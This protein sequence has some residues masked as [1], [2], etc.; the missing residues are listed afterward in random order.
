MASKATNPVAE[1]DEQ[2]ANYDANARRFERYDFRALATATIHPVR[3]TEK[4]QVCYV[5]T[6]DLSR[7]G[8]SILHPV[9][10]AKNQQIDVELS[11]GR[12]FTLAVQWTKRLDLRCY[13]MGC[14]FVAVNRS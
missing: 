8:L 3:P 11:D 5:M 14:R 12:R 13:C 6:R 7:G 4:L 2:L 1:S 9:P 10:L